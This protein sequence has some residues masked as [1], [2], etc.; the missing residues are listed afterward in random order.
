MSELSSFRRKSSYVRSADNTRDFPP[1]KSWDEIEYAL[2]EAIE[3]RDFPLIEFVLECIAAQK[4][5]NVWLFDATI[6]YLVSILDVY[7]SDDTICEK[8]FEALDAFNY[9]YQPHRYVRLVC[10][11]LA[12]SLRARINTD[13][14]VS[15]DVEYEMNFLDCI[16]DE[17]LGHE[18]IWRIIFSY[19]YSALAVNFDI[20]MK[21]FI[22]VNSIAYFEPDTI[23][24]FS[25]SC[26]IVDF[27]DNMFRTN[28][29]VSI[30]LQI[31]AAGI[32]P[33]LI[34]TGRI[35]LHEEDFAEL[36]SEIMAHLV[37][38][39]WQNSFTSDRIRLANAGFCEHC[40]CIMNKYSENSRVS[41]CCL[42]VIHN[43]SQCSTSELQMKLKNVGAVEG[44]ISAIK[45][46]CLP[47][48]KFNAKVA[49]AAVMATNA[50]TDRYGNDSIVIQEI[51]AAFVDL[52]MCEIVIKVLQKYAADA[53]I[54]YDW[55]DFDDSEE[56]SVLDFGQGVIRNLACSNEIN[57]KRLAS[58]GAGNWVPEL[59]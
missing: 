27:A 23:G 17:L 41:C 3:I 43:L 16:P 53:I 2:S 20:I 7:F 49:F 10:D 11:C 58:L 39:D 38:V 52:G 13:Y 18:G 56:D 50:L 6:S 1:L 46:H 47:S 32:A 9:Q 22:I 19:H 34:E 26:I 31:V 24:E 54:T 5:K 42:Q 14:E 55:A 37:C 8:A 30:S 45:V 33:V 51:V 48:E 44:I 40:I 28:V 25:S 21:G 4:K 59:F 35:F 36:S 57:R 12:T 29:T 15:D